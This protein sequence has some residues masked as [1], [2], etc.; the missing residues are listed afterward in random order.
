MS[1]HS[2]NSVFTFFQLLAS[3]YTKVRNSGLGPDPVQSAKMIRKKSRFWKGKT[4]SNSDQFSVILRAKH[5]WSPI[6]E[7]WKIVLGRF[8]KI[9]TESL[10]NFQKCSKGLNLRNIQS[11]AYCPEYQIL[12]CIYCLSLCHIP[13]LWAYCFRC[14]CQRGCA[15]C[16]YCSS[17]WPGWTVDAEQ[18]Y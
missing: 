7:L 12:E 16:R 6:S 10:E 1:I 14:S 17:S 9:T 13:Q 11:A 2:N 3:G 18:A 15:V 8:T 4:C 5:V